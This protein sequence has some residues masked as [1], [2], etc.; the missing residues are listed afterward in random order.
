[1]SRTSADGSIRRI[2]N[3]ASTCA[4]YFK[5]VASSQ[6][7]NTA[8]SRLIASMTWCA[9]QPVETNLAEPTRDRVVLHQRIRDEPAASANRVEAAEPVVVSEL[10]Y[11]K[12]RKDLLLVPAVLLG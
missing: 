4:W 10:N 5:I 8:H 6:V 9:S 11:P 12:L 7:T 3:S 2:G 1:M